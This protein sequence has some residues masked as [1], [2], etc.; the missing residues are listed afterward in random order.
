MN[1][2]FAKY[3]NQ[4]KTVVDAVVNGVLYENLELN[5]PAII[6]EAV[7]AWIVDGGDVNNYVPASIPVWQARAALESYN[8]LDQVN[9]AIANSNDFA[10]KSVWEYGNFIDRDSN[11]LNELGSALNLTSK[12]IDDLFIFASEI[13][14]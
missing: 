13:K 2:T 7:S 9:T 8:L 14:V 10:L 6:P 5:A 11:A 12:Q 3:K 4:E 1:I